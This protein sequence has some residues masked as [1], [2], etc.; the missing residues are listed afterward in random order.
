MTNAITATRMMARRALSPSSPAPAARRFAASGLDRS[1]RPSKIVH[2]AVDD[3]FLD[4]EIPNSP[5]TEIPY[6]KFL[7][8]PLDPSPDS[9]NASTTSSTAFIASPSPAAMLRPRL[10]REAILS[11]CNPSF[12]TFTL[13]KSSN[14]CS[15]PLLTMIVRAARS[16][17]LHSDCFCSCC[18]VLD[19][20]SAK[21]FA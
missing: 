18:M 4:P 14:A 9:G 8:F 11:R 2:H 7:T 16:I 20:A 13:T 15:V 6:T 5:F 21:R 19:F 1:V 10:S 17:Q 3:L 12:L